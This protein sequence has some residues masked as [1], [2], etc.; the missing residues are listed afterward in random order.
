MIETINKKTGAEGVVSLS[1][2]AKENSFAK[3]IQQDVVQMVRGENGAIEFAVAMG[4][5]AET[6]GKVSE[7]LSNG[8]TR[9]G[10]T[11]A[12]T[13]T[14]RQIMQ[15]KIARVQAMSATQLQ[16]GLR[17]H[18]DQEIR[19]LYHKARSLER[20]FWNP[21]SAYQMNQNISQIRKLKEQLAELA[22]YT[23]EKLRELYI[24][25]VLKLKV[26]KV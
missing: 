1:N 24:T 25:I 20:Q 8:L 14:K 16:S 17:H 4:Q 3:D 23:L 7:T 19:N 10:A 11:G 21:F 13:Q 9:T 26:V 2:T 5:I 18:M 22:R 12:A 15:Q 6:E